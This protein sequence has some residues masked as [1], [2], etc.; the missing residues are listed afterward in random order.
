M[1]F[2]RRSP[3]EASL[4]PQF[5]WQV[6]L[7][8]FLVSLALLLPS[9]D[10]RFLWDDEAETALLAK[11]VL[12]FGIPTA[13]DGEFFI[14]QLC[15]QDVGSDLLWRQTPW[16]PIYISALSFKFLG[17]SVFS[18][19]LPFAILGALCVPSFYLLARFVLRERFMVTTAVLSWLTSVP[20]LVYC[21][22]GRYYAPVLLASIW[23]LLFTFRALE[24]RHGSVAGLMIAMVI[25]FHSSCLLF[26]A[27]GVAIAAASLIMG[28]RTRTWLP[29]WG[30][31]AAA[32]VACLPWMACYDLW[33]KANAPGYWVEGLGSAVTVM[34]LFLLKLD[35]YL[36][37]F[38][39]F[40]V[41]LALLIVHRKQ[42]GLNAREQ[43][44]TLGFL[45][46]MI[47]YM[48]VI[49]LP[50]W[51]FFRYLLFLAAPLLLLASLLLG[52]LARQSQVAGIL[53]A[54]IFLFTNL[55]HGW[56][57]LLVPGIGVPAD[58]PRLPLR[59]YIAELQ[60]HNPG[61]IQTA[62]RFLQ[63]YAL[64]KDRVLVSYGD[65]PLRFH[66]GLNTRGGLSGSSLAGWTQPE[67][68]IL[69]AGFRPLPRTMESRRN[70]AAVAAHFRSCVPWDRYRSISFPV[71][72]TLW[73]NIPEP[74]A[75]LYR[76]PTKGPPL[77]LHVRE[78]VARQRG[79]PCETPL[80]LPAP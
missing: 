43:L 18:A 34:N 45:C 76:H 12:R 80:P 63:R 57:R 61:P 77:V 22:Q 38:S 23:I 62:S 39:L 32:F 29:V 58:P 35:R 71:V 54:A 4:L 15:G 67:W 14:S 7:C 72:D 8:L 51:H 28:F 69:R 10:T 2:H 56:L 42:A 73:E 13:W 47:G 25:L 52:V 26:A 21:R 36:F 17:V 30:A 6:C 65:L 78:D 64:P 46:M 60:D 11:N 27:T 68:I 48:A 16:L 3:R 20:L 70:Y 41:L 33:G 31:L 55:L 9:L 37:P 40:G 5:P 49:C 19:R 53:F 79:I 59:D 24:R 1:F 50:G 66:T 44:L 74:E 75:H